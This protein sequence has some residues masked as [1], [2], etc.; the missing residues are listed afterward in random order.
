MYKY[1]YRHTYI[2]SKAPLSNQC[3]MAQTVIH[4]LGM[5]TGDPLKSLRGNMGP[6]PVTPFHEQP[7]LPQC[8]SQEYEGMMCRAGAPGLAHLGNGPGSR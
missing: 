8:A 5:Q 7:L 2:W 1:I 6:G 4:G 3:P